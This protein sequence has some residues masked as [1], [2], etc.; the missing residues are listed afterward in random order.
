[1]KPLQHRSPAVTS[2]IG[3]IVKRDLSH[4]RPVHELRARIMAVAVVV[5]DID[6]RQIAHREHSTTLVHRARQ[7]PCL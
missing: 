4:Q 7:L 3:G 5:K 6:D 2:G 1:M